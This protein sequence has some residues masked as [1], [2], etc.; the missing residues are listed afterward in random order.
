MSSKTA[1]HMTW[2]Q[3]HDVMDEVMM[4]NFNGEA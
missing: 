4:H 3:S 1:E 2:Y